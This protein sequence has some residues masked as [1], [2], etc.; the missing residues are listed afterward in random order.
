MATAALYPMDL[1]K[2]RM[3][4]TSKKE[5]ESYRN[6]RSTI[7]S[8]IESEGIK[9]FY[10]GMTPAVFAASVSWGGYFFFYENAK[11]RRGSSP[12][13]TLEY[14]SLFT[15]H[16]KLIYNKLLVLLFC[17]SPPPLRLV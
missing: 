17:S 4:V 14:V 15:S 12:M 11:K 8:V 2:T 16:L 5:V 9:G 13:G 6:I 10:K 1:I 3:Q 7:K